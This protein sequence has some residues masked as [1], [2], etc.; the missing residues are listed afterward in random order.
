MP[1]HPFADMAIEAQSLV[2]R[3]DVDLAQPG[4]DAVG[5]RDVDNAVMP[6]KWHCGLGAVARQGKKPLSGAAC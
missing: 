2:L 4:V 5:K 1:V 3:H 6:A